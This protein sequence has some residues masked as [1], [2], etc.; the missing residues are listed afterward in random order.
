MQSRKD[1]GEGHRQTTA[2]WKTSSAPRTGSRGSVSILVVRHLG[3]EADFETAT[4][5]RTLWPDGALAEFVHFGTSSNVREL[6]ADEFE[7]WI[8]SF[9]VENQ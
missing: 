7:E 6:T 2:G 8:A 3:R 1:A 5:R 9:P 4:C